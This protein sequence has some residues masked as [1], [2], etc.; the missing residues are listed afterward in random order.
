[1]IFYNDVQTDKL[2]ENIILDIVGE[3]IIKIY[4]FKGN[5]KLKIKLRGNNSYVCF[6]KNNIIEKG[7]VSINGNNYINKKCQGSCV[8]GDGNKFRGNLAIYLP[9][10]KGKEVKIGDNN[11][12]ATNSEIIGCTEHLVFD[13]NNNLLNTENNV[14]IGN[15]NWIGRD[16]MFLTKSGIGNDSVIGIRSVLTKSFSESNVLIAGNPARLKRLNIHWQEGYDEN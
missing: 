1:M 5:G 4:S 7:T 9:L 15:R 12:F 16:V 2:P 13:E 11:L 3:H 10:T 6:G 14:I 8:I